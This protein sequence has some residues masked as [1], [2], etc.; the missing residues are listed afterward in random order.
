MKRKKIIRTIEEEAGRCL[1]E[2][3]ESTKAGD[4]AT[5]DKLLER[6]HALKWVLELLRGEDQ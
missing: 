3:C 1:Q 5:A 4:R 6:G 2:M